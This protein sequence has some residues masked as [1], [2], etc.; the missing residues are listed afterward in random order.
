MS[1]LLMLKHWHHGNLAVLLQIYLHD[2]AIDSIFQYVSPV[3][4]AVRSAM[5]IEERDRRFV[6]GEGPTIDLEQGM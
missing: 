5:E 3:A 2:Y 4:E 1:K 6:S